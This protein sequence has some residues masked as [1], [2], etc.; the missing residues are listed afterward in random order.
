MGKRGEEGSPARG[1]AG[2]CGPCLGYDRAV[3]RVRS[4][5]P[6]VLEDRGGGPGARAVV[7]VCTVEGRGTIERAVGDE[8]DAA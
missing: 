5:R 2:S 4:G 8:P 1:G 6:C 3:G 7:I